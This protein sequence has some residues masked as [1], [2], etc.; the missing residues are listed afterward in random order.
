MARIAGVCER[1]VQYWRNGRFAV[2]RS[3]ILL[4]KAYDERKITPSWLAQSLAKIE[5]EIQQN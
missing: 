3:V 4:A 2:P 5:D 1:T